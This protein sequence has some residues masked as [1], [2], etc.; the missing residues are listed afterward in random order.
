[1]SLF[2]YISVLLGR[3][4]KDFFHR[5][6]CGE[7]WQFISKYVSPF[8]DN[9]LTNFSCRCVL[10]ASLPSPVPLP[11]G[12]LWVPPPEGTARQGGL[13][14]SLCACKGPAGQWLSPHTEGTCPLTARASAQLAVNSQ[15]E[16]LWLSLALATGS[17][18]IPEYSPNL[19]P[20]SVN[21][22]S[23]GSLQ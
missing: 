3:L 21:G 8:T 13:P 7:N 6:L 9:T 14:S 22:P 11:L 15:A 17:I 4:G 16:W 20:H 18:A 23:R 10:Y 1:M 5:L 19:A 12:S 2:K